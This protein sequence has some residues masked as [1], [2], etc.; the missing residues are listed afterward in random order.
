MDS[1]E[2]F[3][4]NVKPSNSDE[5]SLSR[6]NVDH[7]FEIISPKKEA[8]SNSK[9]NKIA[10]S[11]SDSLN[12]LDANRSDSLGRVIR[13]ITYYTYKKVQVSLFLY[14]IDDDIWA[15]IKFTSKDK[16]LNNQIDLYNKETKGWIFKLASDTVNLLMNDL[17]DIVRKQK[18]K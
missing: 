1:K 17:S 8:Q 14:K 3:K 2:I 10:L 16:N 12:I 7:D 9:L 5:Y 13:E 4:V 18:D 15:E 11:L 6:I